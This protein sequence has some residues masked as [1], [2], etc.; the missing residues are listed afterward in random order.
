METLNNAVVEN[1]ITFGNS[2]SAKSIGL[3]SNK[4]LKIFS[5]GN[6]ITFENNTVCINTAPGAK[7]E[8]DN[9]I[10]FNKPIYSEASVNLNNAKYIRGTKASGA[11]YDIVGLSSADNINLGNNSLVTRLRGTSIYLRDTTASVTSDKNLKKDFNEFDERYDNFFDNLKPVTFKYLFGNSNRTHSGFVAQ[12]V[13]QALLNS[14]LTN[15][16]LAI[17]DKITIKGREVEEDENGAIK[18]VENSFVNYLLDN[19]HD[20]E[21]A[22]RYGELTALLVSQI[23]KLKTRVSELEDKLNERN[24]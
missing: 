3:D 1:N 13:E 7:I 14:N 20:S 9:N 10:R 24:V 23:Q 8:L 6:S 18:D 17:V 21:Y 19:G 11:V 22:L 15:E 12:D 2:S 16:D 5:Q 4:N